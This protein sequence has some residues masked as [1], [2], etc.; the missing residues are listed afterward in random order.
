MLIDAW[1][2]ALGIYIYI[3]RFCAEISALKY[4]SSPHIGESEGYC[5]LRCDAVH[6]GRRAV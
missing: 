1:V 3:L 5:S 4:E 6:S 2:C